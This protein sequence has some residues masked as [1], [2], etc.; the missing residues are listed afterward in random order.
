MRELNAYDGE[1]LPMV[2][3]KLPARSKAAMLSIVTSASCATK[4]IHHHL[5]EDILSLIFAFASFPGT[6]QLK[7]RQVVALSR[8]SG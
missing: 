4:P 1:F 2:K 8:R 6:Q 5:G 3:E 7:W